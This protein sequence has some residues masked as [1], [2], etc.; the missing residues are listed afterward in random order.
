MKILLSFL[1]SFSFLISSFGQQ[2]QT[3][4]L[5]PDSGFTNK[6]EATN[7]LKHGLKDGKW[8]EYLDSNGNITS[9]KNTPYY[10]LTVYKDGKAYGIARSYYKTGTLQGELP[11][12]NGEINGLYKGYY[13]S[14]RQRL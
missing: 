1:F 11:Y 6:A 10:S 4:T 13:E 2:T 8:F 12:K 14:G 5:Y 7:Q 3:N 9:N